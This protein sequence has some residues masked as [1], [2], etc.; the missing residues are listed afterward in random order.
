MNTM[1]G[2]SSSYDHPST[3]RR[4]NITRSISLST[5][6]RHQHDGSERHLK[7][8]SSR[9]T[10]TPSD[11]NYAL[12]YD[13]DLGPTLSTDSETE[14]TSGSDCYLDLSS[15]SSFEVLSSEDFLDSDSQS[16]ASE[17]SLEYTLIAP[18]SRTTIECS[19]FVMN[20]S[21]NFINWVSASTRRRASSVSPSAQATPESSSKATSSDA[22]FSDTNST[23]L[24]VA[25][26]QTSG[27]RA[28]SSD[29]LAKSQ[30]R[31]QVPNITSSQR[32]ASGQLAANT[33]ESV[34]TICPYN[35][36]TQTGTKPCLKCSDS[37]NS[38]PPLDSPLLE[39][40]SLHEDP[41]HF[42]QSDQE[43]LYANEEY[44]CSRL[45][46]E[47][48]RLEERVADLEK[49]RFAPE[50]PRTLVDN[51]IHH[52]KELRD[53]N[54]QLYKRELDSDDSERQ[55]CDRFSNDPSSPSGERIRV[56]CIS[57]RVYGE[58]DLIGYELSDRRFPPSIDDEAHYRRGRFGS[59]IK[60]G[61]ENTADILNAIPP[62][63][64]LQHKQYLNKASSGVTNINSYSQFHH[65]HQQR[66]KQKQNVAHVARN[67]QQCMSTNQNLNDYDAEDSNSNSSE[68]HSQPKL[69]HQQ[70]VSQHQSSRQQQQRQQEEM[71]QNH[72]EQHISLHER[73]QHQRK[74][75]RQHERRHREVYLQV[76]VSSSQAS[77]R[78]VSSRSRDA[79]SISHMRTS[80][81]RPSHF[82]SD[83]VSV[84][85]TI[86]QD[87]S[88]TSS[89]S[90]PH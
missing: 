22:N 77:E 2:S 11:L 24:N 60:P 66:Q 83:F 52:R 17:V 54:V 3:K 15:Q 68:I 61:Q 25:S 82:N 12:N 62:S 36:R 18:R 38:M 6:A 53:L 42:L 16:S 63:G 27:R 80:P 23:I 47:C 44:I 76:D 40:L 39:Q 19:N 14:S 90:S 9:G 50:V 64:H 73:Q 33:D 89:T 79:S 74:E 65:H 21:C 35:D 1:H 31:L 57:P 8:A 30:N 41:L 55:S 51:I 46:E 84:N 26:S 56:G 48:R 49:R 5:L 29:D 70:R 28:T 72:L 87:S 43:F 7:G 75:Q 58:A 13:D 86:A 67:K 10:S 85:A 20:A 4:K 69:H 37:E 81:V 45:E 32:S 59:E 34:Q 71:Y 88:S 78:M